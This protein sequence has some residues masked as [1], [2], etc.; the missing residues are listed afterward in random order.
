MSIIYEAL[1]KI[2]GKK[3]PLLTENI[4]ESI[5]LSIQKEE[6]VIPKKKSFLLPLILLLIVL[7]L[8][9]LFFISP[10]QEQMQ[11]QEILVPAVKRREIDPARVYRIP[12]SR[13]QASGEVILREGLVQEYILEG[14]IYDPKAPFALINGR[15]IKESD[16]LNGFRI[17]R[18]SKDKVEMT[19]TGDNSKVTLFLP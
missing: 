5:T 14:I 9:S 3:A 17:D 8:L 6:K 12:E 13:S 16:E 1:K 4:P 15:V 10:K 7:S 18:I 19:N 11:M 2:E